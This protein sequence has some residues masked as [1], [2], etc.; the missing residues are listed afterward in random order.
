MNWKFWQRREP[1]PAFTPSV[2]EISARLRG[3][4]L[5]SQVPTPHEMAELIGCTPISDEVAIMEE[6]QSD[7]RVDRLAL[8][9]PILYAFAKTMSEASVEHQ[10]SSA[11]IEIQNLPNEV[12][13][14]S[15]KL[16]EQVGMAT[17][18]GALSQLVDMGLV[19]VHPKLRRK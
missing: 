10:R 7:K 9:I 17:L 18:L 4:L 13:Q 6:E 8:L 11:D 5:D 12:W 14:Y 1:I 3:F 19:S 15:R 2:A 16:V